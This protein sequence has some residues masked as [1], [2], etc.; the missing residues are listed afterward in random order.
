MSESVLFRTAFVAL[1]SCA[2]GCVAQ[3]SAAE[4]LP[5]P[6]ARQID[7]VKDVQ[8][9]F[10]S[11]CLKCHGPLLQEGEYRLDVREIALT[12]GAANAPNIVPKKSADSPLIQFVAGQVD[13]MQ[14][15]AKGAKLTREQIGILRAWIDQGAH[16]PDSASAKVEDKLAWWSLQPLK[17]APLPVAAGA[18]PLDSF[19]RAKL[20]EQKLLPSPRAERRI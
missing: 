16:W 1:L 8:P 2:L 13:G 20:A 15:P 3:A 14:M 6:A 7:F 5:P 9:I 12:K 4:E 17:S 11:A 19:I 18:N 10:A